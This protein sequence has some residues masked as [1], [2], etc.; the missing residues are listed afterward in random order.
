MP[1]LLTR[2]PI[3]P[4]I[5]K[6]LEQK[7]VFIAGPRQ[8]GK[9]TLA[10]NLLGSET[11]EHPAYL[12]WDFPEVKDPL[13]RGELPADQKLIVLD[14]IHKYHDWRNLVK[15]IYDKY[16]SSRQFLVTGSARLDY[17]RRGGDSL[18]G[19]YHLYR[20]HP[21]SLREG[22][23]NPNKK[24]VEHLLKFGGFP[25]PFFKGEEI[26]WRRWQLERQ[27]LVLQEDM[28]SLEKVREISKIEL[29]HF[30]LTERVGSPLSVNSLREDLSVAHETIEHWLQILENL[31]LIFRI[32]PFNASKI[33]S[34]KK[35]KKLYFW[36]WSLCK[37]E[38]ARFENLVASQLLKYCHLREDTLGFRME[39]GYIRDTDKREI[40]FVVLE[41]NKPK[42]AVEC[43]LGQKQISPHIKYFSERMDIPKFYQ[44]HLGEEY[45]ENITYRT[46]V[47]PFLKFTEQLL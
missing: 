37:D 41:E 33:R 40:D 21:I 32:S 34:V 17:Y 9:T 10:L 20:M 19:R 13:L 36:D 2:I 27:K 42:F 23:D 15:G 3:I 47:I 31:F 6:D 30:L 25:E 28:I 43:K 44:V 7:M 45:F 29:L 38:G 16:K 1:N 39:L 5:R 35:E 26:F 46:T 18:Q 24:D 4:F 11:N 8:V 14:E 22:F 12:N